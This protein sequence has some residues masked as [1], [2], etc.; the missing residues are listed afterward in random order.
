MAWAIRP[1]MYPH[2]GRGVPRTRFRI[3]ASLWKLTE[4]ARFVYVAVMMEK[5]AIAET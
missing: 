4:M 1:N 2:A 3:P 5:A